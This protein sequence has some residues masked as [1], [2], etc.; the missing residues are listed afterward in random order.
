V[1]TLFFVF[2]ISIINCFKVFREI[3]LIFGRYPNDNV[4]MLQNFMNN[5]FLELNYPKLTSA[6]YIITLIITLVLLV[7]YVFEKKASENF[8]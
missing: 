7:M 3:Y 8:F 6:A 4:Y 2:T 5:M 1:P